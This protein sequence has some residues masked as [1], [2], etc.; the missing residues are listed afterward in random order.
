MHIDLRPFLALWVA[1]IAALV[2]VAFYRLTVSRREDDTLHLA[3]DD[4][5]TAARQE[6]IGK[7]LDK[8]DKWVRLL[9]VIIVVFGLLLGAAFLYKSWVLGPGAGL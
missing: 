7:K 3:G 4:L 9:V 6:V 2:V 5:V 1:V 8:I